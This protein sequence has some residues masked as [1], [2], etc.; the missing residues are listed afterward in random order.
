M[1]QWGGGRERKGKQGLIWVRK[2]LECYFLYGDIY[3]LAK[4][5]NQGVKGSELCFK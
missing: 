5:L 4:I 2:D 1:G 3:S